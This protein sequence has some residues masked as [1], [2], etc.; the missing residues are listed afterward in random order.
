MNLQQVTQFYNGCK[1]LLHW[2]MAASHWNVTSYYT[3]MSL[4][5]DP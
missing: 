1:S 2:T 4:Q 3:G 5:P